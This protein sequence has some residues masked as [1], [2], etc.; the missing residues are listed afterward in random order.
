MRRK[1]VA[2]NGQERHGGGQ[3]CGSKG[4]RKKALVPSVM[5]LSFRFFQCL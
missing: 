3:M 5:P 4:G 1:K 2:D